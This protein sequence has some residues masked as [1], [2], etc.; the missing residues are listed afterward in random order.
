MNLHGLIRMVMGFDVFNSRY[1]VA[2]SSNIFLV[3]S[4]WEFSSYWPFANAASNACSS[5]SKIR[6]TNGSFF[7]CFF[8][9]S[10]FQI[11][12]GKNPAWVDC[13]WLSTDRELPDQKKYNSPSLLW[14]KLLNHPLSRLHTV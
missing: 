6:L 3:S 4:S 10:P 1:R 7:G 11:L 2:A 5:S 12:L 14:T 13:L 8:I 9:L